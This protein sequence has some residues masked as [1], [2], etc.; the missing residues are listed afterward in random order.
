MPPNKDFFPGFEYWDT[1][2]FTYLAYA[3]FSAKK[4]LYPAVQGRAA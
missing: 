3:K 1:L 2:D 4:V